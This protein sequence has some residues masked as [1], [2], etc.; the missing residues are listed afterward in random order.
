VTEPKSPL[1]WLAQVAPT[2]GVT[3]HGTESPA[4]AEVSVPRADGDLYGFQLELSEAGCSVS[5]REQNAALLPTFCPD[6][7]I[8]SGGWFCL[9]WGS[10]AP[11][12]VVDAASANDWWTIVIRFLQ[13]QLT[14]NELGAWINGDGDWAH[15][16]A[17]KHQRDAEALAERLGERFL[18]DLRRGDFHLRQ[19]KKRGSVRLDLQRGARHVARLHLGADKIIGTK[20]PCPCDTQQAAPLDQCADHVV[21]LREFIEQLYLWRR[22][23]AQFFRNLAQAGSTCCGKLRKCGLQAA[24]AKHQE[25]KKTGASHAR[26]PRRV[27]GPRRRK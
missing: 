3:V 12:E 27:Y 10:T 22:K 2:F 6:R 16:D 18:D 13:L 21:V 24:V 26:P 20:R 11:P 15:G 9:G 1:K 14:A 23:E 8:N 4:T 25:S 5:V 7:H 17:A 19:E